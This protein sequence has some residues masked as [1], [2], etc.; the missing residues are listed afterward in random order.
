MMGGQQVPFNNQAMYTN[1][2]VSM[3]TVQLPP[4][5][6]DNPQPFD[7]REALSQ[8]IWINENK[9]IVPKEQSI[10]YTKEICVFHV[11]RV[12]D[13]VDIRSSINPI[14]FSQVPISMF[15]S[16]KK[17]ND[18]PLLVP[19][20]L[21]LE[22]RGDGSNY[23][24]R[25]VVCLEQTQIVQGARNTTLVTGQYALIH[26]PPQ[27]GNGRYESIYYIYN[28]FAASLPLVRPG[29]ERMPEY[30][31]NKPIS[32]IPPVFDESGSGVGSFY[33]RASTNGVLFIYAKPQGYDT[34]EPIVL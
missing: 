3:L 16:Y 23:Q 27:F 18:Y 32:T 15:D 2:L 11:R 33:G 10:V 5:T 20:T 14:R 22:S 12:I 28:P 29:S 19:E 1:T 8:T 7:L 31:N 25:S 26:Q 24:L 9:M 21:S 13:R 17:M 6:I 34:R 4:K 30:I